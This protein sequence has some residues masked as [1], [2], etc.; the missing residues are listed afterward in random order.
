MI[1]SS[2]H[3]NEKP[4]PYYIADP[5]AEKAA[6]GA[7]IIRGL[8]CNPKALSSKYFYDGTGSRLHFRYTS[9]DAH[10]DKLGKRG[11]SHDA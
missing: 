3:K 4:A 9:I 8:S 10:V 6:F 7:D 5:E 1:R 11:C 2:I